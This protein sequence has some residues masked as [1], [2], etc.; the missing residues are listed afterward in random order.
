MLLGAPS[1]R[2]STCSP[3]QPKQWLPTPASASPHLCDHRQ[4]IS[5]PAFRSEAQAGGRWILECWGVSKTATFLPQSRKG[6]VTGIQTAEYG[7]C[8]PWAH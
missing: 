8:W 2:I 3:F 7:R 4:I 5:A 1:A 6:S